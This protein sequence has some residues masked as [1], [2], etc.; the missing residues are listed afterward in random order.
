M[1]SALGTPKPTAEWARDGS[2]LSDRDTDIVTKDKSTH[3]VIPSV[4]RGDTGEYCVTLA[5]EVGTEKVPV[6]VIV[7]G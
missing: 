5:N 2:P 6:N 7:L 1:S 4:V 3:L